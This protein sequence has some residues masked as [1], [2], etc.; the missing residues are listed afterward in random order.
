MA[1]IGFYHLKHAA[2]GSAL[3]KLLE[4]AFAGGFRVLVLTPN[5]A[6]AE[7]LNQLLWTYDPASFLPHGGPKDGRAAEQPIYLTATWE[8]P[9]GADML[10]QTG[11]AEGQEFEA[12]RRVLDVFDGND[13]DQVV[14]ARHRWRRYKDGGHSLI[15]WQQKPTGGWEKKA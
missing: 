13:E 9:N 5:E 6:E 4:K 10:I 15:Y 3:A 14:A 2:L 7:R 12:F 8:N 1:E 11:G